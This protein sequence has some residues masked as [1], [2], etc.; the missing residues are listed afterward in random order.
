MKVWTEAYRPF[1]VGGDV[2]APVSCDLEPAS[3][4]LELGKGYMG[5]IVVSPVGKTF[6]V[7]VI[8]GGIVGKYIDEVR[9]DVEDSDEE[10]LRAQ[11]EIGKRRSEETVPVT[12]QEFWRVL[13]AD[14]L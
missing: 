6:I 7:E 11:I 4:P 10:V 1:I 5:V 13:R 9:K 14:S 8:T 3:S 12:Q 2:N